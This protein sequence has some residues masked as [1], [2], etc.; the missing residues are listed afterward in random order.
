MNTGANASNGE[1]EVLLQL[2]Q[3]RQQSE[4]SSVMPLVR[5][6]YDEWRAMLQGGN[7]TGSDAAPY[8]RL[9][10]DLAR[11]VYG[12]PAGFNHAQ[13]PMALEEV[14]YA[15]QSRFLMEDI[16]TD[17]AGLGSVLSSLRH[18]ALDAVPDDA[19]V[20]PRDIRFVGTGIGYRDI[21]LIATFPAPARD[22][23]LG[24]VSLQFAE[25]PGRSLAS[26]P[27]TQVTGYHA[28]VP[29]IEALGWLHRFG[30]YGEA[31]VT[32]GHWF[33]ADGK[34]RE[35][36][37]AM[38]D[39]LVNRVMPDVPNDLGGTSPQFALTERGLEF[40]L[41]HPRLS[42][43]FG[44]YDEAHA[45]IAWLVDGAHRAPFDIRTGAILGRIDNASPFAPAYVTK[46][47]LAGLAA[48]NDYPREELGYLITHRIEIGRTQ[49]VA[50]ED[51]RH[52]PV[53]ELSEDEFDAQFGLVNASVSGTCSYEYAEVKDMDPRHVWTLIESD[54]D[55]SAYALPGFH[56][57]GNIGY[58]MTEKPWPHENIVAVYMAPMDDA[59]RP[60]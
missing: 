42:L 15:L 29:S 10:H 40:V 31:M 33:T 52:A 32:F 27:V 26:I 24:E 57:V 55:D 20:M 9:R 7:M 8:D 1:L 13:G 30:R 45:D 2:A 16:G 44:P 17:Q 53:L 43:I 48:G 46:S 50:M 49:Q 41:S 6:L 38:I 34:G 39:G 54:E 28:R 56:H 21:P 59:M 37:A 12:E 18:R 36:L 5:W 14:Y 47:N 3:K 58:T 19:G 35:L 51:G 60:S 25:A 23:H 4:A 22:A 11:A